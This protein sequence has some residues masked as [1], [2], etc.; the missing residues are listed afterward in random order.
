MT[1][2]EFLTNA[3]DVRI[4][5]LCGIRR[6]HAEGIL[7]FCQGTYRARQLIIV[8]RAANPESLKLQGVKGHEP[9]PHGVDEKT[10]RSGRVQ[11]TPGGP[12]FYSDYD[13]QGVY[14]R[15]HTGD[16]SRLYV[17]NYILPSLNDELKAHATATVAI[18]PRVPGATATFALKPREPLKTASFPALV[19]DAL[20][21]AK[22]VVKPIGTADSVDPEINPFL[23]AI[24]RSVCRRFGDPDMFQHGTQ[25]DY[26]KAGLPAKSLKEACFVA[27]EH[28]GAVYLLP[29]VAALRRYYGA[30][31]GMTWIYEQT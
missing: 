14:E 23:I 31:S 13:L 9:K 21:T 12:F 25:D 15:R 10:R 4:E 6:R 5:T 16:Y 17:G 3:Q 28:T 19:R 2:K 20:P 8:V 30:R 26:R 18:Q 1:P 22:V 29:D 24:N 27:F 7:S 11:V